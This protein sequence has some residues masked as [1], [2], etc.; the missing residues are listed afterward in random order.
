MSSDSTALIQLLRERAV[1]TGD[2]VLASGKRSNFYVDARVVTLH[3]EGSRIVGDLILARLKDEIVAVGG[4]TMGADPVA[5]S[6]ATLSTLRG[7]T[8]HAFLIRKQPKKH[9]TNQYLE[10][11]ANLEPGSPVCI[12]EDT[13]TTGGSLLL[14]AQRA[15]EAGLKVVQCITVVDREEGAA[16]ALNKEGYVLES[17]ATKTALLE[18]HG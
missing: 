17:L 16:E 5:S 2:F 6:I 8:V 18:T 10:G 12:L 1:R 13:T 9:G 3:A 15:T 7:R 11:L 4:L 14:A